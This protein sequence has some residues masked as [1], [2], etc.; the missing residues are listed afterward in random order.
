MDK[1]L[2]VSKR[3][4]RATNPN[5]DDEEQSARF[6]KIARELGVD[7]KA[8]AF[9]VAAEKILNRKPVRN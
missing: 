6:K 3:K 1:S 9:E 2:T 4:Q 7:G 8:T 5:V